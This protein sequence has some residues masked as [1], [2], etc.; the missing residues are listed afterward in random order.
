MGKAIQPKYIGNN[1]YISGIQKD[2]TGD[3]K[4]PFKKES[5]LDESL[6]KI[7]FDCEIVYF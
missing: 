2:A 5:F 4:S 3:Y 7:P 6:I 1:K